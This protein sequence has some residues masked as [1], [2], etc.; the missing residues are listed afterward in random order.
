MLS[1]ERIGRNMQSIQ[2]RPNTVPRDALWGALFAGIWIGFIVG[3]LVM[4]AL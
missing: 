4:S 1:Y 2:T 3:L